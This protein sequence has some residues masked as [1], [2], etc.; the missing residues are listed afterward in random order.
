MRTPICDFAERYAASGAVR[1]HMPGHKGVGDGVERLDITEIAGADSLFE[2]DGIIAESE[3]YASEIF[4]AHTLYSTEGSSLSIRAMVHLV[5]LYAR[6]RGEQPLILAGRNAHKS[7]VS[8]IALTG[9]EVE[10]LYADPVSHLS[11]SPSVTDVE[12][13]LCELSRTPTAI[14]LTSP[15]YL[16]KTVDVEK[17]AKLCRERGILLL[18]DNAHGA[19]LKFLEKSL[20]PMD[21]GAHMCADSAHKT[22]H[23]LTGAAYLHISRDAPCELV[24]WAKDSMALFASTS[25]SYIILESLDR[26]NATLFD[27]FCRKMTIFVDKLRNFKLKIRELGYSLYEDDPM[28]IT[29]CA[30]DYGYTGEELSCELHERGIVVEFADRDYLVLMLSTDTSDGELEKLYEALSL[31]PRR[32]S[33]TLVPPCVTMPE[34]RMSVREA[35]LSPHE[36]VDVESALGRVAGAVT[37]GCPPAVPIVIP[38]EVIG[39]DELSALCYYNIKKISAVK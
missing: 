6:S 27:D 16:G 22:L 21:L 11:C 24:R 23:A 39:D 20:H 8:A 2:A 3:A 19:H 32:E 37:G 36:Y 28:R 5:T 34:R 4:G 1:M 33:V 14:Y 7:F 26:L 30:S 10:W 35:M 29:I 15:D 17:I 12:K 18:I 38:G 9:C 25:P 13:R 31:I